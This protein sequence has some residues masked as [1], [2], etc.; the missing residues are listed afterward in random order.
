MVISRKNMTMVLS[1]SAVIIMLCLGFG[2]VTKY[3]QLLSR[4]AAAKEVSASNQ[5]VENVLAPEL[6]TNDTEGILS[7]Y[8]LERA[9]VRSKEVSLLQGITSSAD[10]PD[11]AKEAAYSKLIDLAD[12]EEKELQAEALVKA[13][14][15]I[16]CAVVISNAGTM[17]MISNNGTEV[18]GQDSIKKSISAATGLADKAISVVEVNKDK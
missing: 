14:G 7:E 17:V 3:G 16:D 11:R 8:R 5:S 6:N 15:C 18:I 2:V 10:S 4:P 1:I 13:Q 9:R 12:R